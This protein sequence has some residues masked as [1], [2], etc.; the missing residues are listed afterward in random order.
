MSKSSRDRNF[1]RKMARRESPIRF[2]VALA[3]NLEDIA[4]RPTREEILF[5]RLAHMKVCWDREDDERRRRRAAEIAVVVELDK[6]WLERE[7]LW[8]E[9]LAAVQNY[10]LGEREKE[11]QAA[12]RRRRE[13]CLKL[14]KEINRDMVRAEREELI[15]RAVYRGR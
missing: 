14:R 8:E 7:R 15:R 11:E 1:F 6:V 9:C 13:K 3:D 10:Y 2:L 4:W 12:D 5:E